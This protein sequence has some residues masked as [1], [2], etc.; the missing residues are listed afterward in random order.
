MEVSSHALDQ[1]RV[2]QINFAVGVFTNLTR[3]H[4]DYHGTIE[5]YAA[6]KSKLFQLVGR[7][8]NGKKAVINLDDS[9]GPWFAR[10][11]LDAGC[12]VIGFFAAKHSESEQAMF[13]DKISMLIDSSITLASFAVIASNR[14]GVELELSININDA[15]AQAN[16]FFSPFIGNYNA[17]NIVAALLAVSALGIPLDA[18]VNQTRSLSQVPGRLE[19]VV[20][21]E[22]PGQ[23]PQVYVDY[24]HTPDALQKAVAALLPFKKNKLF[25]IFGCGGDRDGGK[26]PLMFDAAA[27]YATDVVVTS[28]NPRTEDPQ[29]IIAAIVADGRA[30]KAAI[31]EPDRKKAIV[32]TLQKALP[33]DIVLIAGKGHEDYQIIGTTKFPFSDKQVVMEYFQ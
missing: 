9:W 32:A 20:P 10:A 30:A 14:T 27:T 17:E 3:D 15:N 6:A 25:V 31:I 5:Q 23:Y 13:T 21:T 2:D 22:N 16:R 28:D 4:L 8:H 19:R 1:H 18:L 7:E 33:D 29:A 12:D 24:A 26:R 11:A